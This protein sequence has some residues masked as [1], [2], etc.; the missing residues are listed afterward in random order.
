MGSIGGAGTYFFFP[1]IISKLSIKL[2]TCGYWTLSFSSSLVAQCGHVTRFTK[3]FISRPLKRGAISFFVT[4]SIGLPGI[5]IWWPYLWQPSWAMRIKSISQG[6]KHVNWK[7]PN[8]LTCLHAKSVHLQTS[9]HKNNPPSH[10][11]HCSFDFLHHINKISFNRYRRKG[12]PFQKVKN[13]FFQV[14]YLKD[15]IRQCFKSCGQR[16]LIKFFLIIAKKV[17][18]TYI[19]SSREEVRYN[20]VT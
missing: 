17:D 10:L 8:H 6:G 2:G 11:N 14:I 3:L 18:T 16:Y 12:S 13:F 9:F 4:S 7:E 1:S 20:M 5:W 19:A 15:I